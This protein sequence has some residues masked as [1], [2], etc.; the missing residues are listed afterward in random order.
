MK[1]ESKNVSRSIGFIDLFVCASGFEGR[2]LS[3]ANAID[4]ILIGEA[5]VF[6]LSDNYTASLENIDKI[7]ERISQL[8]TVEHPK[9]NAIDTFDIM[10]NTI[11]SSCSFKANNGLK[12]LVDI[13]TFTREVLLILI[14]ILSLEEFR[15]RFTITF[16]YTPA[17]SYPNEWLTKGIRE[18]RSIF[19][20]AGLNVPSKKLLLIILN[21][22]EIERTEEV[23]NTFEPNKVIL[24]C[25]SASESINSNLAEQSRAKFDHILENNRSLID[26]IFEFSCTDI[27]LTKSVLESIVDLNEADYNIVL[28]PLNNK[29]STLAVAMVALRNEHLQVCY[30]SANQ[31]NIHIYSQSADYFLIYNF[32]EIF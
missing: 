20:Y 13:S 19:G 27:I 2:C 3:F 9:N 7:K 14:K 12:M 8:R 22:F 31:Y 15:T 4:P 10:Y 26:E 5:V 17:E 24:G 32:N 6:N 21:G 18:I 29:I 28:A 23:I 30:A 1:I 25:P 16:S 11:G